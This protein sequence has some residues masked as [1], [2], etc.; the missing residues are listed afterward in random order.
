MS[1]AGLGDPPYQGLGEREHLLQKAGGGEGGDN[2]IG[3]SWADPVE[4]LDLPPPGRPQPCAISCYSLACCPA[5]CS[6]E[7]KGPRLSGLPGQGRVR[8]GS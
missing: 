2:S 7:G 5:P 4:L 6:A 1:R 3:H 8:G